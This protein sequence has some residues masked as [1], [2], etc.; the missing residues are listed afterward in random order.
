MGAG[1]NA[2]LRPDGDI[3]HSRGRLSN[4][5]LPLSPDVLASRELPPSD[6]GLTEFLPRPGC[7]RL[8]RT[9]AVP[10]GDA[11]VESLREIG[12]T[13]FNSYCGMEQGGGEGVKVLRGPMYWR[14]AHALITEADR[15]TPAQFDRLLREM[16]ESKVKLLCLERAALVSQCVRSRVAERRAQ[17]EAERPAREAALEHRNREESARLR[18]EETARSMRAFQ[19]SDLARQ[20]EPGSVVVGARAEVYSSLDHHNGLH[21]WGAYGPRREDY[22]VHVRLQLQAFRVRSRSSE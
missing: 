6:Y 18:R 15:M 7:G 10:G 12:G 14:C 9:D 17:R 8:G 22:R 16:V 20:S 2:W 13:Y 11:F 4:D 1:G 3:F 5:D 21:F 19:A